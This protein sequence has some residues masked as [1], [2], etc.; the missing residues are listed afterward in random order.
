MSLVPF[1]KQLMGCYG[2]LWQV[3]GGEEHDDSM[4]RA[5]LAGNDF[6][7]A[8]A[9]LPLCAMRLDRAMDET[10]SASDASEWAG[11]VTI[12]TLGRKAPSLG[13]NSK[14]H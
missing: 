10:V 14:S 5:T 4:P 9:L 11:S 12:S 3:L 7:Q 1:R 2:H 6:L 8:L 13:R